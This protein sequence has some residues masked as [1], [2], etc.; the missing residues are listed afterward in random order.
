M[1]WELNETYKDEVCIKSCGLRS[2]NWLL[3][4][5][6]FWVP[7]LKHLKLSEVITSSVHN[8]NL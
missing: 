2:D 1:K 4:Q 8:I 6:H 3:R 5:A 7:V